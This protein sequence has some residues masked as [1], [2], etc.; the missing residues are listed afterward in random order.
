MAP[1]EASLI[2]QGPASVITIR[3]HNYAAVPKRLLE[4]AQKEAGRVLSQAGVE[5]HWVDCPIPRADL[6][7]YPPCPE[8]GGL[9][10]IDLNLLPRKMAELAKQ[11]NRTLGLTP[12][13]KERQRVSITMVFVDLVKEHT[14]LGQASV[15]QLLAYAIAHEMGHILLR[16]STHS[17]TGIMRSDWTATDLQQITQ[18]YL[19]FTPQQGERM[20]TELSTRCLFQVLHGAVAPFSEEIIP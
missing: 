16:T 9:N 19:L 15:S 6:E 3:L 8:T 14:R 13:S 12:M 10:M 18:G 1:R 5:L 20:R 4:R 7:R 11:P 2:W 17:S